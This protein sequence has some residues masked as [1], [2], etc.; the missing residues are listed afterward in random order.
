MRQVMSRKPILVIEAPCDI[1]VD[2]LNE[3]GKHMDRS[4][5]TDDYYILIFIKNKNAGVLS[6]RYEWSYKVI[7]A[8][9]GNQAPLSPE[10]FQLLYDTKSTATPLPQHGT[11]I[12]TDSKEILKG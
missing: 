6:N 7:S 8:G 2:E 1:K 12:S 11:S 4:G 9:D 10:Q 5:I 3:F